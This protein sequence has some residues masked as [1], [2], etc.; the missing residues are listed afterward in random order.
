MRL[1]GIKLLI[2]QQHCH[3][4]KTK[5]SKLTSLQI[6]YSV[7]SHKTQ[8]HNLT[9]DFQLKTK[10]IVLIFNLEVTCKIKLR[11]SLQHKSL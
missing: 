6:N 11:L 2:S 4:N 7:Y 9:L 10:I 5:P 1:T 8:K 3:K